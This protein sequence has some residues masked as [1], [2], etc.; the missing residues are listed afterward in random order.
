MT[1]SKKNELNRGVFLKNT[2]KSHVYMIGFQNQGVAKY[3]TTNLLFITVCTPPFYIH[4]CWMCSIARRM[5][6]R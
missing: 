3:E 5:P 2:E 4:S 6:Q 1:D